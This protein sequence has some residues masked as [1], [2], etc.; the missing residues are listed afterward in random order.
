MLA[1][2]RIPLIG[3]SP[4]EETRCFST[5]SVRL[6]YSFH[7]K[8]WQAFDNLEPEDVGH[9]TFRIQRESRQLYTGDISKNRRTYTFVNDGNLNISDILHTK[10]RKLHQPLN[11]PYL[12][13][14]TDDIPGAQVRELIRKNL[15]KSPE[16]IQK[17]YIDPCYLPK[18]SVDRGFIKDTLDVTVPSLV[19]KGHRRRQRKTLLLQGQN[20]QPY[21][22]H[23]RH[24]RQQG[25]W[26]I[27]G[28]YSFIA[29]KSSYRFT[30]NKGHKQRPHISDQAKREPFESG[31]HCSRWRPE[32][33]FWMK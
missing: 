7:Y 16:R 5:P 25:S 13:M 32:V 28:K 17:S 31:V 24:K 21:Q 12:N 29:A 2:T 1:F 6:P 18:E 11:K 20:T 10:P 30:G 27:P 15:Q 9:N 23:S 8:L 3:S 14:T 4:N 26:K 33:A 19:T 22:L